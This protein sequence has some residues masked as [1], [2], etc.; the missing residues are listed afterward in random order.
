MV[1]VQRI[2]K[3]EEKGMPSRWAAVQI[4]FLSLAPFGQ[5]KLQQDTLASMAK[6]CGLPQ[7]PT[8]SDCS[9]AEL[10]VLGKGAAVLCP[11]AGSWELLISHLRD[12]KSNAIIKK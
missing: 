3:E 4:V 9:S 11:Q 1:T 10:P 8:G 5:V 7:A 2:N 6:V 12:N